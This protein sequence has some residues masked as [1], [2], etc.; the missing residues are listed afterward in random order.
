MST[1][2]DRRKLLSALSGIGSLTT[3][4]VLPAGIA[5]ADL[6]PLPKTLT[7][8]IGK[9]SVPPPRP[10]NLFVPFSAPQNFIDHARFFQEGVFKVGPHKIWSINTPDGGV[11]NVTVL[12]GDTGVVL[13]DTSAGI[14]FAQRAK[15][16]MLDVTT[17][18]V[19]AVIYT[20]H[21]TDHNNGTQVF[22]S[23][24]DAASGMVK[25]IAADNFM[26]ELETENGAVGPIMALRAT[27][28]YGLP[29]PRDEEATH[30]HIGCC[31]FNVLASNGFLPPNQTVPMDRMT[32][33]TLAGIRMQIFPTG[34]E[35]ASHIGIFL[36]ES[37][38]MLIGDEVQGPTFPQLHS[39]RG[40]RP[41][42]IERWFTAID[43]VRAFN[44]EYV[45]F[46]HGKPMEGEANISK[47]LTDYRDAMQY[48]QDQSIRLMNMGFTPDELA[49]TVKLP[50]A[51]QTEPFGIEYYGNVDVS[52]RNVYGGLVSWWAGDP[53]ELR[54][55]P[56]I[57]R[58][59]RQVEMMGGRDKVFAEAERAFFADDAQWA[60]ELTTPLIRTNP[61]DWPARHL[62]AAALRVLGYKQTSSSLR[63][64]YLSGALE[65]EG[66]LDPKALQGQL[67]AQLLDP[68]TM[69]S[70]AVLT[71][72]RFRVN[73]DRALDQFI[74]I[75]YRFSDTSEEFTLTLRNAVLEVSEGRQEGVDARA[76]MTRAQYNKV[77]AGILS[78]VEADADITGNPEAIERL[79]E[80]FDKPSELPV[81]HTTLR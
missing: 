21:H 64:F 40:T 35:A 67:L 65:L 51:L 1:E 27:Y 57:E 49:E 23:P 8:L 69:P 10:E 41:R 30:F 68:K 56:R 46:G 61:N 29:L 44:P 80:L 54:P 71:L 58:A 66:A 36:P 3:L 42:D 12:E 32:E 47:M 22:V 7:D 17:K 33:L 48:V 79:Y 62:K 70:E 28:M 19:V 20:H 63:G 73:P 76:E 37:R 81:P 55:T 78:H 60:A 74:R 24:A 15:D 43:R 5:Y 14:E 25:I 72:L 75:G 53:A 9:D 52:V 11:G 18:P 39:L 13:V 6:V 59:R 4:S 31:G 77:F 45:V 26:R 2:I 50:A 34:G 16:L 38:V